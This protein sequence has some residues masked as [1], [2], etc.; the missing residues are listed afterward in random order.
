MAI[1]AFSLERGEDALHLHFTPEDAHTLIAVLKNGVKTYKDKS[2]WLN[3]DD[4]KRTT[5]ETDEDERPVVLL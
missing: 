2:F 1:Y 3:F 4:V 5:V